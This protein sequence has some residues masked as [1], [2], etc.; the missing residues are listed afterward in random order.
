MY[1]TIF[2]DARKKYPISLHSYCLM[3]NHTHLLIETTDYPINKT[4]QY[5]NFKYAMYFNKRHGLD[6]HLFQGRYGSKLIESLEHFLNASKYIHL[7]PVDAGITNNPI[8]YPWSSYSAFISP[9]QNT[10]VTT[11]KILSYFHNH[12]HMYYQLFVEGV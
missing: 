12:P 2:A 9:T 8:D 3:T 4:M 10:H 5:L 11:E 6:G 7:N 1:L